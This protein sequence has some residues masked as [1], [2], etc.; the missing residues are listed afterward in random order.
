MTKY[1]AA[2]RHK[3]LLQGAGIALRDADMFYVLG[4]SNAGGAQPVPCPIPFVT[5][6][7][8]AYGM[9]RYPQPDRGISGPFQ[10]GNSV[11]P[12]FGQSAA[13]PHFAERWFTLT[14]RRSLWGNY[15]WAGTAMTPQAN[16]AQNWSPIDPSKS[17][18]RDVTM[19]GDQYDRKTLLAQLADGARLL[20][21]FNIKKRIAVW[22][23]GEADSDAG[24]GTADYITHLELMIADLKSR[25]NLDYF[26]IY[27]LGRKG[28]DSG[29]IA[30]NEP[31]KA[32]IR[33][34]QAIVCAKRDDT[35]MVFSGC[36]QEGALTVNGSGYHVSGWEYLVDGVHN[37]A[38]AQRCM[39][40][41]SARNA[42]TILSAAPTGFTT[43]RNKIN[44][45]TQDATVLFISDSRGNETSEPLYLFALDLAAAHPTH[46]VEYY[47]ANQSTFAGYDAPVTVQTGTG[48]RKIKVYN[49]AASGSVP[50]FFMGSR[51]A[52]LI[53]AVSPDV[54]I[55]NHGAN[56]WNVRGE[57]MMGME[58][59]RLLHP[60][61]P[62]VGILPYPFRDDTVVE[63]RVADIQAIFADYTDTL[64]VD[65]YNP[66]KDA[67][68]PS[69]YYLDNAHSSA[70]GSAFL[71]N[72]LRDAYLLTRPGTVAVTPAGISANTTAN[73][74]GDGHFT[75]LIA[76]GYPT[77][78][79]QSLSSPVI[80]NE[81]TIKP[82]DAASSLKLTGPTAMGR[83]VQYLD[84][85][86]LAAA[87]AAGWVTLAVKLYVPAGSATSVGRI[88]ISQGGTGA[89]SET[90]RAGALQGNDE[91]V[92]SFISL[93]VAATITSLSAILYC[94]SSAN[95]SS[96]V[97]YETATLVAGRLPKDLA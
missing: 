93:P 9:T 64:L 92:W 18:I 76:S 77:S 41:T 74:L 26:L 22:V 53:E 54:V 28:T 63:G 73:L 33:K 47:L 78:P 37:T 96:T 52:A 49:A 48:S 51:R 88:G 39:G 8:V 56:T 80:A 55:W 81:T 30:A 84:A 14:G 70:T 4:Q 97:Y 17:L 43:L 44:A 31:A 15:A 91:W 23:Q 57:F 58:L 11:T 35:F 29:S 65:H 21:R 75:D 40:L 83:I 5:S 6:A 16:P 87:K 50:A 12:G 45:G 82:S 94:D 27:E 68:K 59:V 20:A 46:T 34:A 2:D 7:G 38:E 66:M 19:A 42:A 13:W 10:N 95:A 71:R 86:A 90:M 72:K 79:W 67:G 3:A 24:V 25:L 1:N 32:L 60:N 36:K 85:T 62:F 89:V 69:G 61:A